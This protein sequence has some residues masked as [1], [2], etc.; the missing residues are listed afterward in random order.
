MTY[1]NLVGNVRYARIKPLTGPS[2]A[3]RPSPTVQPG[4][5][6]PSPHPFP[7]L[8]HWCPP[9][10]RRPTPELECQ[11]KARQDIISDSEK[12]CLEVRLDFVIPTRTTIHHG[13]N[14]RPQLSLHYRR[15]HDRSRIS[16]CASEMPWARAA[17][18]AC[19]PRASI[20]IKI[21]DRCSR[22]TIWQSLGYSDRFCLWR[23]GAIDFF[24]MA[25]PAEVKADTAGI[26]ITDTER[27][28]SYLF[29]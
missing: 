12:P 2:L 28:S 23:Y 24:P 6:H 27:A 3:P 9:D 21:K 20:V 10:S 18:C 8:T 13:E 16:L 19:L 4:L 29:I 17:P 1:N 26:K 14:L 7:G 25:T 5:L 22:R 11:G 15:S